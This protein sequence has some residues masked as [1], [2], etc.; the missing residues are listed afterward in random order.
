MVDVHF[1]P[2]VIH[3]AE[4][5]R[6]FPGVPLGIARFPGG[7]VPVLIGQKLAPDPQKYDLA[8]FSR[9]WDSACRRHNPQPRT[10]ALRCTG[11]RARR[12]GRAQDQ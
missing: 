4:D 11:G 10:A 6:N 12:A 7:N 5:Q 9:A 2:G 8:S 3:D 1:M